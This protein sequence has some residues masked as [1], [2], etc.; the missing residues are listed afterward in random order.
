MGNVD[1]VLFFGELTFH[2]DGG[3]QPILPKEWDKKLG[4]ELNLEKKIT[5]LI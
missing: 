3:N 2:H 4:M 5:S 1:G